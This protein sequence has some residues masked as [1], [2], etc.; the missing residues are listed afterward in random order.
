MRPHAISLAPAS[1]GWPAS[2]ELPLDAVPLDALSLDASLSPDEPEPEEVPV[3]DDPCEPDDPAPLVE[4]PV[5]EEPEAWDEPEPPDEPSEPE[6]AVPEE[7]I[8]AS[9]EPFPLVVDPL[10]P[11]AT[12][13]PTM[14]EMAETFWKANIEKFSCRLFIRVL[15]HPKRPLR[16]GLVAW[17]VSTL[18]RVRPGILR[19]ICAIKAYEIT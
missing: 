9:S 2:P 7:P 5:L 12:A 3:P 16:E 14:M 17:K 1:V 6:P 4:L 19:T 15:T 8:A 10:Q 18:A 11:T 13:N